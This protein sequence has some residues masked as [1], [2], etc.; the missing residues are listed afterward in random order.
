MIEKMR[1]VTDYLLHRSPML[2]V[3]E[4]L[5]VK[6]NDIVCEIRVTPQSPFCDGGVVPSWVGL[7]YMAQTVGVLA[8]YHSVEAGLPVRVGFL[9]GCRE[10]QNFTPHFHIGQVIR[11][12]A[13]QNLVGDSKIIAMNCTLNDE[14]GK[15]LAQATLL[16][17]QPDDLD[18]YLASL[19]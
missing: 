2:L 1:P 5:H 6:D 12:H 4:L 8:G 7:E 17:Y 14:S 19:S 13:T 16:V 11:C 3:D 15:T 10:Y 18:E 9:V